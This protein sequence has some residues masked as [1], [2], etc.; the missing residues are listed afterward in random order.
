MQSVKQVSARSGRG[1]HTTRHV[2]LLRMKGGNLLA[3]TPG[4]GYP[5]L[6]SMVVKD[7]ALCFPEIRD[8]VQRAEE[9]RGE[10]CAF[11]DCTHV[12]EPGCVVDDSNWTQER[13]DLYME[14]LEEVKKLAVKEKEAAYKRETRVRMKQAAGGADRV[15]AKLETKS[16]RRVNRRTHRMVTRDELLMN[17]DEEEIEKEL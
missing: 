16:H 8:A 14:L 3:D 15:E 12:H 17:D 6:E 13:L 4:F 1:K 5:S 9:E 10:R 7:V 11:T 2:S